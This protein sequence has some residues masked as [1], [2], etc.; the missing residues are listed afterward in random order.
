MDNRAADK[1]H[2]A[3][4]EF[5]RFS[6]NL[7]T[8]TP[9]VIVAFHSDTNLADVQPAIPM[10][11]KRQDSDNSAASFY[12]VNLPVI[13]NVSVSLPRSRLAGLFMTVPIKAG[14]DCLLIFSDRALDEYVK[15]GGIQRVTAESFRNVSPRHHDLTDPFCIPGLTTA[16][17]AISNWNQD[18]IEI[19]NSDAS[20]KLSI[21]KDKVITMVAETVQ[22]TGDVNVTGKIDATGDIKA[23]TISL[24]THIHGDPQGGSTAVPTP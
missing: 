14:D 1:S 22:I 17:N 11:V 7:R 19:R 18:A 3:V 24:K 4:I 9:G 15:T 10:R 13:M 23:A 16:A 6:L 8:A 20:V 21:N 12:C 5:D 2:Q